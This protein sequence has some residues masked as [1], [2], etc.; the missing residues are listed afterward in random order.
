MLDAN[1]RDLRVTAEPLSLS[2]LFDFVF[3]RESFTGCQI[4]DSVFRRVEKSHARFLALLERKI[5][6]YGVTTGLGDSCFRYIDVAQSENLQV[7]LINYLL[8]GTGTHLP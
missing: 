3:H 6:I 8:C 2:Q 5:P 4:D 7:N 1:S